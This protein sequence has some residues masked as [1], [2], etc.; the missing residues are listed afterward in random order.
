MAQLICRD[1]TLGYDKN[2]VTS[3]LCFSLD[4]GD[5]LCIVGENG[6]GKS[7]LVKALMGLISPISGVIETGDGLKRNEI[8]YL[9]QQTEVQRD[10][11]ATVKEIVLSGTLNKLGWRPFYSK[12]EKGRVDEVMKR[13]GI[14]DI[15]DSCYRELS[16]GQQQKVLLARALCATTKMLVLDEPAAGLD[17]KA[18]TEMY[19]LIQKLNREDGITVIMVSHDLEASLKYATHLLKVCREHFHFGKAEQYLSMQ[20]NCADEGE[21]ESV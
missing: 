10:F 6:A 20:E 12:K 7:T 9:P 11:P 4:S 3:D 17:P 21:E 5:Y 13:L 19:E 14:Y 1:L 2:I 8:G 18:Q 16:G 15:S